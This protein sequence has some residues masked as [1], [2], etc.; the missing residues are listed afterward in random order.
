M[1]FIFQFH[2]FRRMWEGLKM[3][4]YQRLQ[5][6]NYPQWRIQGVAESAAAPPFL[7]RFLFFWP[8]FV[9]F[10]RGIE[11]F[12]FPAPPPLFTDPGS[13][14]DPVAWQCSNQCILSF[15]FIQKKNV[16]RVMFTR[17][18]SW[19]MTLLHD[20]VAINAFYLSISFIQKNVGRVMF[21][22]DCSWTITLSGGSRGWPNR[23]RPPLFL[24]DFCY[25]HARHRGI[26]IPGPPPFHRSWIRLWPCCMTM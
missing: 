14:S 1:H 9:I 2:S 6:D 10:M 21:T 22:R 26:W 5:L 11:E 13:A 18:C 7:G 12:G 25:F 4:V 23:P 15:N 20:N 8:I 16:G 19:T 3:Y 17:D 24:A